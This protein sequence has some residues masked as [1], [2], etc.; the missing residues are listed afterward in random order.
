[1]LTATG[2]TIGLM[3]PTRGRPAE[4]ERCVK[5]ALESADHP[6]QVEVWCYRDED[7]DS[8]ADLELPVRWVTGPRITLSRTW[9]VLDAA[10]GCAIVG[11]CGDDV[12]FRT[13]GWDV[14]VLESFEEFTDRIAFV[15]GR[16]GVQDQ[17]LGTH[18]FVSREWI[19]AVGY[20]CPPLFSHD[21]NDTWLN[22]VAELIGR[23]VYMPDMLIEHMHWMWGKS[24]HDQTYQEHEEFGRRDDVA[25]LWNATGDLR[26]RD[27]E[28]LR[29][30]MS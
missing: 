2:Q 3:V 25:G 21:Y 11:H 6:D 10:S 9:N 24:D 13:Y 20:F 23:R 17:K 29:A 30:V 12:V 16:D 26:L 14:D 7:D 28:R 27:A 8:Y 4:L 19:D 5:S 22:V 15:Y 18:G 1:M